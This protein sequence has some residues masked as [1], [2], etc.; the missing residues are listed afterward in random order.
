MIETYKILTGKYDMVAASN[1]TTSTILTT[2]G[3][4]LRLQKSYTR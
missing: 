2:G 1:L 3:N 4:D